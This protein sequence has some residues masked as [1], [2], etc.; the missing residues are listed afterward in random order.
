MTR[1][2]YELLRKFTIFSHQK[3]TVH[4]AGFIITIMKY[5][6]VKILSKGGFDLKFTTRKKSAQDND[7]RFIKDFVQNQCVGWLNLV[8]LRDNPKISGIQPYKRWQTDWD[9][10]I[11]LLDGLIRTD[12]SDF[13][14]ACSY[15]SLNF[16]CVKFVQVVR[17][18]S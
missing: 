6:I 16:G 5:I 4:V 7:L 18:P 15:A 11:F 10:M 14:A 9:R 12:C 3:S 17:L 13:K 2:W 1:K 8:E